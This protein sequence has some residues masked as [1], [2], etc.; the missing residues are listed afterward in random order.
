MDLKDKNITNYTIRWPIVKQISG[1]NSVTNSCN[2]GLSEKLVICNFRDKSRLIS[3]RMS[4]A[5]K[6]RHKSKFILINYKP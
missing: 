1:Y 6:C 3:K 4:L 5:S 2:L